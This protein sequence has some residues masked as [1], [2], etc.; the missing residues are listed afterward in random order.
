MVDARSLDAPPDPALVLA[1]ERDRLRQLVDGLAELAA[2]ALPGDLLMERVVAR[3]REMTGAGG[4]VVELVDGDE[5]EY[6]AATGSIAASRGLR[7]PRGASLSGLCVAFRALQACEDTEVDRRV[8]REACRRIGARSMLVAPLMHRDEAIGVVKIVWP[9]PRG[10]DT[11]DE[12]ALRLCAGLLA[13]IVARHLLAEGQRRLL[14]ERSFA[15]QRATAILDASPVATLVHDADG[16]VEAWNPAAERLLGWSAAEAVGAPLPF[17]PPERLPLARVDP[18][19]PA[20]VELTAQA[21][22]GRPLRLRMTAAPLHDD[23]GRPTAFVRTLE[24]LP[25]ARVRPAPSP[26]EL[27]LRHL[28][29]HGA[30]AFVSL[31]A[32]GRVLEWNEAATGLFGWTASEAQGRGFTGLVIAPPLRDACQERLMQAIAQRRSG[33][34]GQRMRLAAVDR[35]GRPLRLEMSV[36]ATWIDGAP[37]FDAFVREAAGG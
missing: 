4:A 11:L 32:D 21:R 10:F 5:L 3:V 1:R 26:A 12:Y 15:L 19:A 33:V 22:D 34:L 20:T 23:R 31:D 17:L 25:E 14:V 37:V 36:C 28:T 7:L 27:R 30:D 9:M 35:D 24:P 6:V 13:G 16:R 29:H 8:D 2:L 18:G